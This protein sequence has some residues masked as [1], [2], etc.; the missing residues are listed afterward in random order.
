MV[1]CLV[2]KDEGNR[3]LED[4]IVSGS[5]GPAVSER[6]QMAMAVSRLTTAQMVLSQEALYL[7]NDHPL[8]QQI[9]SLVAIQGRVLA[10]SDGP[11]LTC[12]KLTIHMADNEANALVSSLMSNRANSP[13][14]EGVS[15][16]K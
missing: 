14:L 8:L 9:Q 7:P 1:S 2:A 10:N 13:I 3:T 15:S 12:L 5:E 16:V 4:E 6:V 11:A